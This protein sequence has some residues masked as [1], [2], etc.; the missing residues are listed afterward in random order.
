VLDR[1]FPVVDVERGIVVAIGTMT[2]QLPAGTL[3]G[4]PLHAV[5]KPDGLRLQVLVEFFKVVDGK[6]QRIEAVMYDLDDPLHPDPGW[7]V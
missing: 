4:P 3:D 2:L 1:R 5:A 7:P 6:I